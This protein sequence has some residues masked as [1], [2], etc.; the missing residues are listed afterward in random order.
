MRIGL[1]YDTRTMYPPRADLPPDFYGEYMTED[2]ALALEAALQSLGYEVLRLG[3]FE[4]LFAFLAAGGTVDGVFNMAEGRRGR[5]REAWV[6]ALLEA[7]NIPYVFSDPATL[8]LCLDKSLAKHIWR[9]HGLPTPAFALI[10]NPHDLET[11]ELPPFPLFVKPAFE[12]TSKGISA[13]SLVYSPAALL[14]QVTRVITTYQQPALI[15]S[16]LPGREFTVGVLG[17]FPQTYALGAMEIIARHVESPAMQIYGFNEK[18]M[19][20]MLITYRPVEEAVLRTALTQLAVAAYDA[21]G[22]R[23]A[24]RV[25][26]RMDDAGAL[27]LLE[28]NPLPGLH[29]THSDLPMIAAQQGMAY[30]T[31]IGQIMDHFLQRLQAR[32]F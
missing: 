18:E 3:N 30:E 23:D 10:A 1:T 6:P 11:V 15:E 29:P 16:F 26:V 5:S 27:W 19:W 25:D 14:A 20:Q 22:C 7:F 21:V 31:L 13:Q 9:S 24:G 12:G 8:C 4:S 2:E 28:I 17:N 32:R